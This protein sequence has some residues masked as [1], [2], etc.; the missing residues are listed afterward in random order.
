[1]KDKLKYVDLIKENILLFPIHYENYQIAPYDEVIKCEY[2]SFHQT[3][4]FK[5]RIFYK[6]ISKII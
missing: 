5:L 6:V 2:S 3:K 4:C 1:M